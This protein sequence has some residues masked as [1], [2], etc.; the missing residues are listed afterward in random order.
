M[1]LTQEHAG[2]LEAPHWDQA[3]LTGV[4]NALLELGRLSPP[5]KRAFGKKHEVDPVEHLIGAAVGWGGNPPDAATYASG[6]A[7]K[8]DGKTIYRSHGDVPVGQW[9]GR[10]SPTSIR[11]PDRRSSTQHAP[12]AAV[13]KHKIFTKPQG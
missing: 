9:A 5:G 7:A 2:T 11:G 3:S 8:N 13:E 4:R 10:E 6:T 12:S 1:V